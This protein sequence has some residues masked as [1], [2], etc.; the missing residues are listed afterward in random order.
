MKPA[1]LDDETLR[2]CRILPTW[3]DSA[4]FL[5]VTRSGMCLRRKDG[6]RTYLF[7]FDKDRCLT[8]TGKPFAF[9][10]RKEAERFIEQRQGGTR[11]ERDD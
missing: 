8:A 7:C 1:L 6:K 3:K 2:I 5:V 9:N 11:E 4:V 10:S